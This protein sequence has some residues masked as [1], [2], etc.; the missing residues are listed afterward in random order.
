MD[1]L[2]VLIAII[3]VLQCSP[4]ITGVNLEEF[5]SSKVTVLFGLVQELVDFKV[6]K[7]CNGTTLHH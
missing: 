2:L 1:I 3:L 5:I 7:S 4:R 6:T